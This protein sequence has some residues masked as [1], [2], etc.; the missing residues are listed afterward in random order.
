MEKARPS[1]LNTRLPEI[2][3]LLRA[4]LAEDIGA[5]DVTSEALVP[6]G[7]IA[8]GTFTAKEDGVVAGLPLLQPLFGQ[9]DPD[10]FVKTPVADGA[11][12]RRGTRLAEVHASARALLAGERTALN[13]LQHL[14]GIATRT[15][16]FV[17]TLRNPRC[18]ILDTRKTLPGMRL[19]EK[20]A[21]RAGGG[22]NHR[23]GLFDQ[24]LVKDNH[25]ALAR[26]Q[27]SGVR[28][29]KSGDR[30]PG[31]GDF[32]RE[33]V[34]LA[35]QKAPPGSPIEIEVATPEEALAAAEGGADII[36]LDNMTLPRIRR[37]VSLVRARR[38]R[39]GSPLLEVSG[40]VTLSRVRAIG[41]AGVDRISVGALTHSAPALDIAMKIRPVMRH[42]S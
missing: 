17:Q 16:R 30:G 8:V 9:I 38:N 3:A 1:S 37:A 25:L 21:V 40:G 20:Y 2:Q 27:G 10:A 35:R 11:A 34:S 41:E 24:A 5:G 22:E 7:L 36:L 33:I 32:Y 12:V 29:R 26:G 28:G 19:L 6:P 15:R 42:E 14:S 4:A 31:T 18:R 23:I 39:A 13:F